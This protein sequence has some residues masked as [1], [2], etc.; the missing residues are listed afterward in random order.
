M[1][2]LSGQSL[3]A[4][5]NPGAAGDLKNGKQLIDANGNVLTGTMST[6]TLPSPGIT[7]SN[8]GLITASYN[9][10]AGYSAGGSKSAT[11]QLTTQAGTTITPGTSQ[12]TAVASGRYTTGNVY[13]AGDSDLKAS[14]IK[15]GV[16]IFG[17]TGTLEGYDIAI[18][19]IESITAYGTSG[20]NRIYRCYYDGTLQYNPP[21]GGQWQYVSYMI[22]ADLEDYTA[23]VVGGLANDTASNT[24]VYTGNGGWSMYAPSYLGNMTSNYFEYEMP[25][26]IYQDHGDI[27]DL[28]HGHVVFANAMIWP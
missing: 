13:V 6:I 19:N 3:P 9:Q 16:T 8:S 28:L 7:V 17:V 10:D 12:K 27:N 11:K 25:S 20:G 1:I 4:L 22:Q 5:S 14:N 15:D 21:S 26:T 18:R 24:V 23:L 2:I